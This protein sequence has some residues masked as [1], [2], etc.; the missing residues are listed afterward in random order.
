MT[1]K[2]RKSNKNNSK[3]DN[4]RILE[5]LKYHHNFCAALAEE[6]KLEAQITKKLILKL[7]NNQY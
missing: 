2:K 6:A 5:K 4:I 3:K 1:N 7:F